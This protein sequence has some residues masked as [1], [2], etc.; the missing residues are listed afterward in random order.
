MQKGSGQESFFLLC[1]SLHF[2]IEEI[3]ISEKK[4]RKNYQINLFNCYLS[5]SIFRDFHCFLFG[6]RELRIVDLAYDTKYW[7]TGTQK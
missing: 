6:R 2:A 1:F 4:S 3:K 7:N 5:A